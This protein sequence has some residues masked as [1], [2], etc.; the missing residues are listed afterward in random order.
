[1]LYRLLSGLADIVWPKVCLSCKRKLE[2]RAGD[3]F[4]C[5]S[6][7]SS[8]KRNT[9]PFCK[10]CG[11]SL[12]KT[13]ITK[14]IC[15]DCIRK[16]LHFDSASSPCAYSGVIKELIHEFK[17]KNKDYLGLSLSKLMI[18]FIKEYNMPINYVDYIIPIP[19]HS[20]RLREREFNQ[21][22]VL[23]K[24]IADEFKINVLPDVLLRTKETKTQTDL[25]MH[26][27]IANVQNSFSVANREILKGKNILL[28][29]DV[30]TTGATSSEAAKALK[31]AGANIVF[32]MTLAD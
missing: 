8:I 15:P 6:C 23:S 13:N 4:I 32:V 12:K 7:E 25:E 9:P 22:E 14:S 21:A 28:V 29:D 20:T 10:S 2:K 5:A 31:N 17:Y 18:E 26:E 16:K 27:R 30:L 11:R 19:L 3:K 24:H 1:M